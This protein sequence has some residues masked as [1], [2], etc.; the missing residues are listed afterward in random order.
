MSREDTLL[1]LIVEHVSEL[2]G[3]DPSRID[4]D[5]P[6]AA[7]GLDSASAL[8]LAARLE[9]ELGVPIGDSVPWDH[10]TLRDLAAHL[11][12]AISTPLPAPNPKDLP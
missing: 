9:D 8:L 12:T 5:A 4:P 10:P 11:A 2:L 1:T 3:V 7:V 6:H